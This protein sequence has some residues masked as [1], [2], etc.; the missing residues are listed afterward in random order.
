MLDSIEVIKHHFI[1]GVYAKE[2]LIPENHEVIS[3]K[4]NFDHMSVLTDGC[5]IVVADGQQE[6]YFSP[7]IIEIKAGVNHSIIPVNGDAHWLC[8]HATECTDETAV[9]EVLIEKQEHMVKLDYT[10]DVSE[11][12]N[13]IEANPSLWD[14]YTMRTASPDSPHREVNDIWLRFRD[15]ADFDPENP[16][17]MCDEH[18]SIFYSAYYELPA[19]Q[20][21]ITQV[22]SN[23]PSHA[24]LGGILITKI[25]PGKQ[26]YEH[27][28]AGRWHSEYYNNKALVLLQ[29]APGQ[30]FNFGFE[31][32]EGTDGEVFSFNNHPA[33]SVTNNSDIDRISLILAIRDIQDEL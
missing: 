32:H 4:H 21:I 30:S 14:R 3:H 6:T 17:M 33:H 18:E 27:S 23:M 10:V 9:D 28:D 8:I 16:G 22:M 25:P 11:A 13:Q 24:K 19:V 5:V 15:Y 2:M 31:H 20:A 1:G 26:V 7:A 12:V 29:S